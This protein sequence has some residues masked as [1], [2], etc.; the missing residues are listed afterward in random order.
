MMEKGNLKK[1]VGILLLV[2]AILIILLLVGL[3]FQTLIEAS[4]ELALIA[5][6]A[7]VTAGL[8]LLFFS[9]KSRLERS[10]MFH[11]TDFQLIQ[12]AISKKVVSN[13]PDLSYLNIRYSRRKDTA[14]NPHIPYFVINTKTKKAYW[15]RTELLVLNKRNIIPSNTHKNEA[16]LRKYL[17][18]NK[19]DL[20]EDNPNFGDLY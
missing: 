13:I 4:A 15:V 11:W 17:K 8:K 20:T 9:Q 1:L 3:Q 5:V 19:I 18:D 12:S 7:T 6:G 16:E 2:I 14:D 10:A